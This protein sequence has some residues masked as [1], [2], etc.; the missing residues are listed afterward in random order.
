M[1]VRRVYRS[2]DTGAPVL[3]G[4]AGA[5][6]TLLDAILVNG[7]ATQAI[8]S[9]T[10]SSTTVTVTLASAHG[11]LKT[12]KVT[13]AGATETAYNGEF[14]VTV[15][16]L[17][18]FTYTALTTPSASPA[19][20]STSLTAKIAGSGWTTAFTGTNVRSYLQGATLGA[21][22]T[23]YM[24]VDD[25][26]TVTA[27]FNGFE[28]QTSAT[29]A[30]TGDF[31]TTAQQS[32][33]LYFV[34]SDTASTAARGWMAIATSSSIAIFLDS[35]ATQGASG[36][37]YFFGDVAPYLASDSY[38]CFIQGN[39]TTTVPSNNGHVTGGISSTQA[40]KYMCRGFLQSGTSLAVGSISDA[41][42][43]ASNMGSGG[44]VYP[45]FDGGLYIAP[46]ETCETQP[47]TSNYGLRGLISG[48]WNPLHNKPFVHGDTI[49]GAG[50]LAGKVF[51]A[52]NFYTSAQ[53][54]FE[55]S[56]T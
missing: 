8:S 40:G 11:W 24:F 7:Y 4:S 6:T 36:N 28:S 38:A 2:T 9:M 50:A 53:A 37:W 35:S 21:G 20:T 31:P 39:T 19:T 12:A 33:G 52:F 26:G 27:R 32:G 14:S 16:G 43:G 1:P 41:N 18:T 47:S 49:N 55:I 29:M 17:N 42:R 45:S 34:K 25:T 30:G 48:V 13:I 54:L 56:D 22:A 10:S 15:T 46:V 51:Q 23:K 5:L 3:S 44:I